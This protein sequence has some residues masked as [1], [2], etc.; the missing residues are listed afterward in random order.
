MLFSRFDQVVTSWP[1]HQQAALKAEFDAFVA[2]RPF[3]PLIPVCNPDR[4]KG[5]GRP[6][7]STSIAFPLVLEPR[8]RQLRPLTGQPD[9]SQAGRRISSRLRKA[10]PPLL[11]LG[12][13]QV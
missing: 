8:S 13:L 3:G 2:A 9:G 11:R 1:P 7:G 12:L 6:T 10:S 5:K 4:I